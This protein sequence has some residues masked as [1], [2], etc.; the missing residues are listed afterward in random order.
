MT[1]R[2][3]MALFLVASFAV[4]AAFLGAR[5]VTDPGLAI[6]LSAELLALL[7]GTLFLL[8]RER[9][10]E[11]RSWLSRLV[12]A[13]LAVRV[14]LLLV[15]HFG[16]SP[17]LFAPDALLYEYYGAALRDYW[18]GVGA[19]PGRVFDS[20]EVGYFFLNG[21]SYY[22]FR[23]SP[24]G[25]VVLNL[26]TSVWTCIL[27]FFLGRS[28]FSESVGKVSALLCAFF[29]S[30]ILWSVL[31]IRDAISTFLVTGLVLFGV[32][33]ARHLGPKEALGLGLGL[34][35]LSWMRDYMAVLVFVGLVLGV[36]A[37]VRPDRV[38]RTLLVGAAGAF[39]IVL[40]AQSFGLLQA[41]PMES[42]LETL[43][44][45][46]ED[47]TRGAGSAYGALLDT[48]TPAGLAK[49]LPI[50]LAYFLFAPF[51]W[52]IGSILEL[53]TL[54]EVLLWYALIPFTMVG[55]RTAFRNHQRGSI[56]PISV[57]LV[58]VVTYALVEGNVGTA[59]R[60][61]AQIMPV[62]FLFTSV[63]IGAFLNRRK[64]DSSERRARKKRA[65]ST[66]P[67]AGRGAVGGE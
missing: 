41:V 1:P 39:A 29:P 46:R 37:G 23:E 63:G 44:L 67:R 8:Q 17:Y 24:F 20:W 18:M 2:Q 21:G 22:L 56:L 4:L 19:R 28:L 3:G 14:V 53:A 61:R 34:L 30:L 5:S 42:P 40:A 57:L 43:E 16:I 10:R 32:R 47:F 65:V 49:S 9:D 11:I 26:F 48:S 45:V 27:A 36:V 66:L 15:V 54:P 50:G 51:P 64:K 25:P 52:A 62:F 13:A 38:G 12:L 59:Y 6:P 31:N 55:L 35:L 7:G 58:V 33:A 60:H